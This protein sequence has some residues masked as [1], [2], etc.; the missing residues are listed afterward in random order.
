MEEELEDPFEDIAP[1][2]KEK[3]P[4]KKKTIRNVHKKKR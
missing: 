2:E 4:Q 3:K 1:K